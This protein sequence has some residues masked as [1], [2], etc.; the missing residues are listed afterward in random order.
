MDQIAALRILKEGGAEA[1][2]AWRQQAGKVNPE[3]IPDL[4]A[5]NLSEAILINT[6]VLS[7]L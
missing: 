1:R 4:R 6:R 5:A 3:L 7:A 2:N